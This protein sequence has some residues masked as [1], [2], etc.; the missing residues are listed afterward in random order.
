[1][2]GWLRFAVVFQ[3]FPKSRLSYSSPR[4]LYP[5]IL[6]LLSICTRTLAVFRATHASSGD[7]NA[8]MA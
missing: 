7:F 5:Q 8:Y 1:M 6:H 2:V 4:L 3:D